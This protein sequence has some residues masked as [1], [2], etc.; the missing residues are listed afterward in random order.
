MFRIQNLTMAEI[1]RM[2]VRNTEHTEFRTKAKNMFIRRLGQ[3]ERT[4]CVCGHRCPQILEL[5]DGDFAA[6][7]V[8]MTDEAIAAMPPGPG[9]GANE[10][11]VRIPRDVMIAAM[12][13]IPAA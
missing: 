12:A 5:A 8:D 4:L 2:S 1:E 9:V 13:E 6:V 7:G 3:N 11:I 10:R